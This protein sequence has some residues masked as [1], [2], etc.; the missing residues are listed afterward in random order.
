SFLPLRTRRGHTSPSVWPD[1][2]SAATYSSFETLRDGLRIEVRAF[3]PDDRAALEVAVSRAGVLT[4][5][6]RFFA[7]KKDFSERERAFFLNVDFINHVA[8][9][10]LAD[11]DGQSVIVGGG[12]YVVV[13]PG[14]AEVAFMVI[15]SYQKRGVGAALMKHLAAVARSEGVLEFVAE[16]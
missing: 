10:A 13:R 15:D 12:R 8:L 14:A 4:R 6:R 3:T 9:V 2:M 11:E 1:A 7:V 5:Y 16:V